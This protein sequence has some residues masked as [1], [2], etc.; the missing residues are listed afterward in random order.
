MLL[1][2]YRNGGSIPGNNG[3]GASSPVPFGTKGSPDSEIGVALIA[4]EFGE[5]VEPF[6]T[7]IDAAVDLPAGETLQS[8]AAAEIGL[9]VLSPSGAHS[10]TFS[11][12]EACLP[13]SSFCS[14]QWGH[15]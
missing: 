10:T 1:R 9:V 13:N 11:W 8:L 15:Q 3:N 4:A 2:R 14:W 12:S 6:H 7:G 5:G